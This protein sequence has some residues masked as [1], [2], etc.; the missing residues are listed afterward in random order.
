MET[1]L[2]EGS[3]STQCQSESLGTDHVLTLQL[4]YEEDTSLR[5]KAESQEAEIGAEWIDGVPSL[6]ELDVS[7]MEWPQR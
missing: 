1:W 5:V 4:A 6:K 3:S 2:W 7:V